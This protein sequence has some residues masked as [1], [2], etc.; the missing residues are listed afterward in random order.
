MWLTIIFFNDDK[1]RNL[2]KF[3]LNWDIFYKI[4]LEELVDQENSVIHLKITALWKN[5]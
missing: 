2:E 3:K 1:S 5:E 4:V